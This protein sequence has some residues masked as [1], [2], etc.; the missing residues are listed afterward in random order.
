MRR[1]LAEGE[2]AGFG[3]RAQTHAAAACF[4]RP[5]LGLNGSLPRR[6]LHVSGSS[7]GHLAALPMSCSR[8]IAVALQL[9]KPA[10]RQQR[11]PDPRGA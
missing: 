3:I 2:S 6:H 9:T 10:S 4:F 11:L 5:R 8:L 7:A 1:P